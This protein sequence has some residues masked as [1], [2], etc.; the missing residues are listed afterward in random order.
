[1]L[2]K[3]IE[4]LCISQRQFALNERPP[5]FEKLRTGKENFWFI[6]D[7]WT[8]NKEQRTKVQL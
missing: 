8:T 5:V 3:L 2:Q 4:A 6:S 1:V 7:C